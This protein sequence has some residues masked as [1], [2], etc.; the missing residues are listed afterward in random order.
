[1]LVVGYYLFYTFVAYLSD[2]PIS[3]ASCFVLGVL[4]TLSLAALYL[5]LGWGRNYAAHQTLAL[6]AA[7]TIYYPLAV[8]MDEH[9]D[10]MRQVLYW[11][12]AAYAAMLAV[13]MLWRRRRSAVA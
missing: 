9:M 2:Y 7:F 13:V 12:L 11:F 4:A 5:W 3:F 6:V 10:L 8:V 1:M